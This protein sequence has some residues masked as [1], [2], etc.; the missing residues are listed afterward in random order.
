MYALSTTGTTSY[1][2]NT[3]APGSLWLGL[4]YFGYAA[5]PG[6][7]FVIG[8]LA[9]GKRDYHGVDLI[10]R[11]RYSDNWQ[12]LVSY[13]YNRAFGNTNSDSNADFQGDVL[14]L[15]PRAPNA[16]ARQ[17]GNIPHIFKFSG[18][19]MTPGRRG[20]RRELSLVRGF[21]CEPDGARTGRNLP[22]QVAEEDAYV[23]NG[24][25]ERWIADGAVGSLQNP[26]YG[27]FDLR[28]QYKRGSGA[29]GPKCSWT[30]STC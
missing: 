13:T 25:T 20:A 12:A 21:V 23:F 27:Q 30:S 17:P 18:S 10:Y 22:I 4:D 6:S 19:Y 7:N 26:S 1:P 24:A 8:T 5:N 11:K 2:G 16:Y 3:T 28:A 29:S 14:Y 9:G 15:D